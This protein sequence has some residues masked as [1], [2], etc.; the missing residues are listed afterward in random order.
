MKINLP[1]SGNIYIGIVNFRIDFPVNKIK[2][3][4][5]KNSFQRSEQ[6]LMISMLL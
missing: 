6:Y 5:I 3:K 2:Q 4:T 1:L